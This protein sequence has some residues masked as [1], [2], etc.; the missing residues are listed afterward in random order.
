MEQSQSVY[1]IHNVQKE[2]ADVM[3]ID[4][5]MSAITGQEFSSSADIKKRAPTA[6]KENKSPR[7]VHK[8]GKQLV[9]GRTMMVC[10]IPC[11]VR[12]ADLVEAIESMG[13]A[14]TYEFIHL[15]ARREQRDSNLGYG[16]IHFFHGEDAER[17][18]LAFEGYR[19]EYKASTKACTVKVASCQGRMGNVGKPRTRLTKRQSRII[20]YNLDHEKGNKKNE[21]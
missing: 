8:N 5:K 1:V 11:R 12:H 20:F 4:K 6:K 15:P 18:A 3:D 19:F 9:E 16:F 17:F 10:N 2:V 21:N 13:F 7:P 14:Q